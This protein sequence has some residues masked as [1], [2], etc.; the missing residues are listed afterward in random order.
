MNRVEPFNES[1]EEELMELSD[2]EKLLQEQQLRQAAGCRVLF[3]QWAT[4]P[5]GQACQ[6]STWLEEKRMI[7]GR[8]EH[9]HEEKDIFPR[10]NCSIV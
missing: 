10:K 2:E 3:W 7:L 4:I 6:R 9:N 1:V 5:Q 8:K